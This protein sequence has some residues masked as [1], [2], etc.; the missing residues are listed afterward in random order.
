MMIGERL[1]ADRRATLDHA[2]AGYY[3]QTRERTGFRDFYKYLEGEAEELSRLLRPFATGSLRNLLS[4]EGDD[5]LGN[6]ALVTV[7]DLRL[8][9]PELRPA[10]AMVCTE[11]V[12]QRLP[13]TQSPPAGRGRSVVHHAAPRGRGVHGQHGQ[14]RTQAQAR[15]PVHHPGRAGPSIGGLFQG[16]HRPLGKGAAPERRLQAASPAGRGCHKH[17]RRRLRPA[18]GTAALAAVLP[19][20]RRAA[21]VEGTPLP[22][23]HRGDPGGDR[24]DRV[25]AGQALTDIRTGHAET[26]PVERKNRMKLNLSKILGKSKPRRPVLLAVTP[27]RTGERTM[28]GVENMLQSIAVPEPFSLELAG[29]IDGVTL[30]ARCLDDQVVRGQ[31]S[32][33]YPQAVIGEI[34]ADEDPLR[35]REGEGAWSIT[36]RASGPEYVPLRVFRDDDLL[37]PGSD[38]LI[39]VLGALSNLNAGERI[40]ARLMLRSMGPD[41]SQ[42]HMEKAHTRAVDDRRDPSYTYQTRPLQTDGVTLAVLGVGALAALR[43]YLWVQTG[44]TWKAALMGAGIAVAL[45]VGGWAWHRWEEGPQPSVR[46]AANQGEGRAHSVR[47]RAPGGGRAS[48]DRRTEEGLREGQEAA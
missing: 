42:S 27:P 8:L 29:D 24:G 4:D 47:R 40:V 48:S 11:T 3:A 13:R 28:L 26:S 20:R 45:A 7:F 41:W 32:A 25:D 46:P 38:P 35:V 23:A 33:H 15:P 14:A 39:A 30:M 22:G 1:S 16:H 10:A 17:R 43:C 36:M 44:E 18:G 9:E 37:D 6:E 12:W 34:N 21:A 5:L 31:V 19:A 2:L